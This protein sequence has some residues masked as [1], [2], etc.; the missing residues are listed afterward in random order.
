MTTDDNVT[1][2]TTANVDPTSDQQF[3]QLSRTV[4]KSTANNNMTY[5][6]NN[7]NY[8]IPS[9]KTI[10]QNNFKENEWEMQLS[11]AKA[12]AEMEAKGNPEIFLNIMNIFLVNNGLSLVIIHNTNHSN[13]N[14]FN[15]NPPSP[16]SNSPLLFSKAVTQRNSNKKDTTPPITPVFNSSLFSNEEVSNRSL[17]RSPETAPIPHIAQSLSPISSVDSQ[18]SPKLSNP[19]PSPLNGTTSDLQIDL[20]GTPLNSSIIISHSTDS[21]SPPQIH[22]PASTNSSNSQFSLR[23]E[24][25]TNSENDRI[26]ISSA[27]SHA[28][29]AS[30]DFSEH[31]EDNCNPN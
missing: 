13:N 19:P 20:A 21:D 10:N 14:L 18:S 23:L 24:S 6:H 8:I 3:P 27:S 9:S 11:I 29:L 28:L 17:N 5:A 30:A 12:Y 2:Q 15:S 16:I 1:T 26:Q 4:P 31:E 7:Q 25:N 22:I